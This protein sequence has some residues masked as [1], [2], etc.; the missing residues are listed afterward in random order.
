MISEKEIVSIKN[1]SYY[2]QSCYTSINIFNNYTIMRKIDILEP[3]LVKIVEDFTNLTK[4]YSELP[5]DLSVINNFNRGLQSVIEGYSNSDYYYI[6]DVFEY[7]IIPIIE[8]IF[9]EI[10][11]IIEEENS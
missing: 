8:Q 7:D 9:N 6:K 10:K 3:L 1:L 4:Y 2:C 11:G 5:L